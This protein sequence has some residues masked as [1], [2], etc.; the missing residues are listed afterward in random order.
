MRLAPQLGSVASGVKWGIAGS[1]AGPGAVSGSG[2]GSSPSARLRG[3][4]RV[5]ARSRG[6]GRARKPILPKSSYP[7]LPSTTPKNY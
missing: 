7:W 1:G 3:R 2:S 4:S 5:R 6:R